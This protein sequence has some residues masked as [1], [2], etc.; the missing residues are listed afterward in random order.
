MQAHN[1]LQ[2]KLYIC[3]AVRDADTLSSPKGTGAGV[4]I[5]VRTLRLKHQTFQNKVGRRPTHVA[6]VGIKVTKLSSFNYVFT[7]AYDCACV[8]VCVCGGGVR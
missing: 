2:H 6:K 5:R 4:T 7:S 1:K 8:R 3:T